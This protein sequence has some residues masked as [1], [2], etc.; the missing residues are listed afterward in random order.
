M[1]KKKDRST[2]EKIE[3]PKEEKKE[4]KKEVKSE[5]T[6]KDEVPSIAPRMKIF[7]R[8]KEEPPKEEPKVN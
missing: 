6:D 7:K 1:I 8:N 4:E 3:S 2:E 5:S